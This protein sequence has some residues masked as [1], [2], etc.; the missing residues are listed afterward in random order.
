MV[1]VRT[2]R[3]LGI[4]PRTLYRLID[5]GQVRSSFLPAEAPSIEGT[6]FPETYRT[7]VVLHTLFFVALL[8]E[9]FPWRVPLDPPTLFGLAALALLMLLRYWCI[10]SLGV[11]WNTRILVLPGAAAVRRG[12]YRLLKH[13]NYLVV[14]LEFAL[15]PLLCRAPF[16]LVVFSLANLAVLRRRIRLE[17]RAL[18][19]CTD[20][21]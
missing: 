10:A 7:I 21:G 4:T 14:T 9:S 20:W 3:R 19:E 12:P 5:S 16:T 17:E 8:A 2:A 6:L 13:P 11:F 18:R 1:P 15:L